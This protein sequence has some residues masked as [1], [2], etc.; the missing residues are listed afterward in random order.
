MSART[1]SAGNLI[2]LFA[3]LMGLAVLAGCGGSSSTTTTTGTPAIT[4]SATTLTFS[5]GVNSC[6]RCSVGDGHR[7]GNRLP[8][9][10]QASRRVLVSPRP[11]PAARV[12]PRVRR[13]RSA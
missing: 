8:D 13:A 9:L 7:L 4:L 2:R 6:E 12:F 10:L 11:T 5:S 3:V 1:L